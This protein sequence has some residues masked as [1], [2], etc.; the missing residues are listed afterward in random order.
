M[1][2][3]GYFSKPRREIPKLNGNSWC[4]PSSIPRG[5]AAGFVLGA[6]GLA[7]RHES[8]ERTDLHGAW[9]R[10]QP[11]RHHLH[12][13]YDR[14]QVGQDPAALAFGPQPTRQFLVRQGPPISADDAIAGALKFFGYK[15]ASCSLVIA[16]LD[17]LK[18]P[19]D[20]WLRKLDFG[21]SQWLFVLAV[22][23]VKTPYRE[24]SNLWS[25]NGQAM[26]KSH[27]VV[28][29]YLFEKQPVGCRLV[30]R[31]KIIGV[32]YGGREAKYVDANEAGM[33][34]TQS[35][36]AIKIGVDSILSGFDKRKKRVWYFHDNTE[37]EIFDVT[38]HAV[39]A[40]LKDTFKNPGM[41]EIIQSDDADMTLVYAHIVA[42]Q[43]EVY[44]A[45]QNRMEYAA[46][47]PEAMNARCK[48]LVPALRPWVTV[49]TA[50]TLDGSRSVSARLYRS[51]KERDDGPNDGAP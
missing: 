18:A 19:S 10:L 35:E 6:C 8:G 33:E 9:I 34:L 5:A 39:W 28:S 1:Y 21:D 37:T 26:G 13:A 46:L 11:D 48:L 7:E 45:A 41:Y 14:S 25:R 32:D 22:E 31:D 2:N 40:A 17:D 23:Y 24:H 15:T 44:A 4:N 49:G 30:W 27:A 12:R 43:H 50:G 47:N 29:G 3:L 38:C 20:G 16:T 42:D 51:R 36:Q